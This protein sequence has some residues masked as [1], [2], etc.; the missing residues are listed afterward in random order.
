M[1]YVKPYLNV[2]GFMSK[3][4]RP[5]EKQYSRSIYS[6]KQKNK[7]NPPL[8]IITAIVASQCQ[9]TYIKKPTSGVE[10]GHTQSLAPRVDAG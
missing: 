8:Q 9:T 6:L 5:C 3:F 10:Q 7:T 2:I 1:E 4:S